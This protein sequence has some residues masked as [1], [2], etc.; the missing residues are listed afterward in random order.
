MLFWVGL[1][2][3]G[4]VDI[5]VYIGWYCYNLLVGVMGVVLFV[6]KICFRYGVCVKVFFSFGGVFRGGVGCFMGFGGGSWGWEFF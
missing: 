1:F 4:Y 6:V 2:R 3:C 5:F